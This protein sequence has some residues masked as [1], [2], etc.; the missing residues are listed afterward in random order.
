MI[1]FTGWLWFDPLTSLVISVIIVWGTW[2]ILRDA[3]NLAL[4]AVPTGIDVA[5]VR[6]VFGGPGGS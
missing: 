6:E 3:L 2:G 4:N 5:E 1:L